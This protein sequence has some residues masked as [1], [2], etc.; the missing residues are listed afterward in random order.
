MSR[1]S[2]WDRPFMHLWPFRTCGDVFGSQVFSRR[3]RRQDGRRV[4]KVT[5]GDEFDQKHR[6]ISENVSRQATCCLLQLYP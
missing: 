6:E 3:E 2:L 1:L 5:Q 4:P